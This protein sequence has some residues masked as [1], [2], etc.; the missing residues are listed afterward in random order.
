MKWTIG[1]KIAAGYGL[2]LLTLLGLGASSFTSVTRFL[3]TA[4][5][6]D[7]TYKVIDK[8][9]AVL[10]DLV[11]GETGERGFAITGKDAFLDPYQRGT[12][13][14]GTDLREVRKLTA[15]NRIQQQLLDELEPLVAA[16]LAAWK[17]AI[18][19][20]K[21]HGL[22]AA[23]ADIGTGKG[24]EHMDAIRSV[25]ARMKKTEADLLAK[26]SEE[27]NANART[28]IGTLIVGMCVSAV[29]LF[30]IGAIIV[31]SISVPL[32]QLTSA[33]EQIASGDLNVVL[34]TAERQDEIGALSQAFTRM[35][36]SLKRMAQ[37]AEEVASGNL[38]VTIAPQ[39]EK[40]VMGN[41]LAAMVA[42]L[43]ELIGQVQKSGVQVNTSTTEIAATS[44]QQQATA[45]EI[46]AT[47]A[48]IS[49][50]S[51]QIAATAKE[52]VKAMEQVT[53]VAEK[54]AALAGSG[55][56][57][58]TRMEATMSQ[59]TEASSAISARLAV[60]NEKAGN[61]NT[62]VT[63]I[64]KVADQTNLLSLNAAIEAEKAGEYGRGFG[65]V[66]TEIRRLADQTAGA[67]S[68]IE[69]MV[70]DMQSA[71]AAG[72]MGMDKFAEE[73]RRGVEV[74]AQV[75]EELTQIIEQ[76][77]TLTPNFE[78]VSE[79][80]QSQALGAEQISDA[81]SQLGEA[82]QQT[83]ESLRQANAAIDQLSDATG[84]LQVGVSRFVL[85][86]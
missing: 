82:A 84:G 11:D 19:V 60:L 52:L 27:A 69:Q 35:A 36:G 61:I 39:S 59:I 5:W 64:T 32:R 14:V 38:A 40:D 34:G 63:T 72:V 86:A 7:H 29:L 10:N 1:S 20:R 71:V 57:G 76:V 12:E 17:E 66:A 13:R 24:K 42:R 21:S 9:D 18:E 6:V 58:L 16:R 46:S 4:D 25:I 47:T 56:A 2:A 83:V 22:E 55:Q 75:S 8:T 62:V 48:E 15:D 41:A 26:R 23:A 81:L 49:A 85:Q 50:T 70:K 68:D 51:K 31:R 33:S 43:G 30:L 79:G 77:Q 3:R 67:T 53:D 28:T 80:M 74:V 78:A 44:K 54:T 73:V 65:V 45:S 37:G